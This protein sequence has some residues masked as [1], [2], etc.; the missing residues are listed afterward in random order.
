[1]LS[2]LSNVSRIENFG[3]N[4]SR[5]VIRNFRAGIDDGVYRCFATR[6]NYYNGR[7]ETIYV[8]V[9]VVGA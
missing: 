5:M 2:G 4:G 6:R 7:E 1:M 8:Q 3:P 9:R